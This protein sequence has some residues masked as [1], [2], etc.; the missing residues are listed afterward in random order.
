MKD[1]LHRRLLAAFGL[2]IA[3]V[4]VAGGTAAWYTFRAQA[5]FQSL[6]GNTRGSGELLKANSALWQLRYNLGMA[7]TAD[8]AGIRKAMADEAKLFKTIADA[9]DLYAATDISPDEA[10]SIGAVREALQ[11]YAKVRPEWY[12]LG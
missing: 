7:A 10:R 5:D 12:Q 3:L 8:E 6:Y 2:M 9:I 11:H 1:A 4:A